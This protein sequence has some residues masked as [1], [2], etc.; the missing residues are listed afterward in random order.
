MVL[1]LW[2]SNHYKI[3]TPH[4]IGTSFGTQMAKKSPKSFKLWFSIQMPF[5]C[6][7]GLPMIWPITW[8]FTIWV[9]KKYKTGNLIILSG[10]WASENWIP[11]VLD[12]LHSTD[13]WNALTCSFCTFEIRIKIFELFGLDSI[14][15]C[16]TC[17]AII[18][19]VRRDYRSRM[20]VSKIDWNFL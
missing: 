9:L 11:T 12:F 2:C 8:L 1:A 13:M 15:H 14:T 6:W 20:A 17:L 19:K 18:I 16:N 4:Q 10:F 3:D 5:K 7:T